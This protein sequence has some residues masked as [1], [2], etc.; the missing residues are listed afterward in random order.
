MFTNKKKRKIALPERFKRLSEELTELDK[1][2]PQFD[3]ADVISQWRLAVQSKLHKD[4]FWDDLDAVPQASLL[5]D[6]WKPHQDY[7]HLSSQ[8][9]YSYSINAFA[10][11]EFAYQPLLAEFNAKKKKLTEQEKEAFG[12]VCKDYIRR[13]HMHVS[14]IFYSMLVRLQAASDKKDRHYDNI[15]QSV[16][17]KPNHPEIAQEARQYQE[18]YGLTE[19]LFNRYHDVI[20]A[21]FINNP[22]I[23]SAI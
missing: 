8:A 7:A 16:V 9:L 14:G 6:K 2:S 4:T 22:E 20:A 23:T 15:T 12:E 11:Y 13:I 21:C 3:Q 19:R 17:Q 5:K 1:A 10:K 18:S